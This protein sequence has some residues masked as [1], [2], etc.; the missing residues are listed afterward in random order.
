M[1]NNDD[2]A[3]HQK[4]RAC[5]AGGEMTDTEWH[6]LKRNDLTYYREMRNQIMN[7]DVIQGGHC[8]Q[9]QKTETALYV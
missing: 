9:K 1:R 2:R 5:I 8:P 3:S 7:H 6:E 4:L